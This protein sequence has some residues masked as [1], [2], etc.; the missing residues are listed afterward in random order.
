MN[1]LSAVLF[2]GDH[3]LYYFP[4][5]G[6]GNYAIGGFGLLFGDFEV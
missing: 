2:N 5:R 1:C 3:F 4:W 6:S